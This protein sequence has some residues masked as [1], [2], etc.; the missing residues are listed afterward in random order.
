[1]KTYSRFLCLIVVLMFFATFQGCGGGYGEYYRSTTSAKYNPTSNAKAYQYTPET[2]NQLLKSGYEVIGESGFNGPAADLN[3]AIF[4]AN[5]VG[6]DIVLI[7]IKHTGARQA[8]VPIPQYHPPTTTMDSGNVQVYGPGGYYGSGT[9]TGTT[10]YP[11]YTTYQY[12]PYSVQRYDHDAIF[13]RKKV[14]DQ[15]PMPQ[16]ASIQSTPP[17]SVPLSSGV[18]RGYMPGNVLYSPADPAISIKVADDLSPIDSIETLLRARRG[19]R[20]KAFLTDKDLDNRQWSVWRFYRFL[21]LGTGWHPE[22]ALFIGFGEVVISSSSSWLKP[23]DIEEVKLE[24]I[25]FN[26]YSGKLYDETFDREMRGQGFPLKGRWAGVWWDRV[27]NDRKRFRIFYGEV[28][29]THLDGNKWDSPNALSESQKQYLQEVIERGRNSFR[30]VSYS[31][32]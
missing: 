32:F 6:A 15:K 10:T 14:N 27:V 28:I 5:S 13:L 30:I 7:N 11:G 2:L 29:P 17:Q 19:P 3:E 26:F 8:L 16:T 1:M 25:S 22:R 9:Y 20:T 4:Q 24:G 23:E 31:A 18:E 12:M 21:P